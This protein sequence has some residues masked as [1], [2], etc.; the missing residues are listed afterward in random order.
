MKK[1]VEAALNWI[2]QY[3]DRDGD[4]FVEYH[5]ESSKGIANQGWKDSGDSIVHRNG[6]YAKKTPIALAEVQ[7]YVY[8]AKTGTC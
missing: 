1:N 6:E 8:Q 2:D 3:G 5:Q 4:L 7:G